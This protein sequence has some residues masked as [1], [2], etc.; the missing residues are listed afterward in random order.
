LKVRVNNV[1]R[2]IVVGLLFITLAAQPTVTGDPNGYYDTDGESHD[3]Y[4]GSL[5]AEEIDGEVGDDW[6]GWSHTGHIWCAGEEEP[7][8]D[9]WMLCDGER[10]YVGV[11]ATYAG[12]AMA[13]DG[14]WVRID[15][16]GDGFTDMDDNNGN[17]GETIFRLGGMSFEYVIPLDLEAMQNDTFN[18]LLHAE[19]TGLP[20][21]PEGETTTFPFRESGKFLYTGLVVGCELENQPPTAAIG[22]D[23]FCLGVTLYGSDSTD[24]DGSIVSYAWDFGDGATGSGEVVEHVYEDD[25]SYDVSLTVTDDKGYADTAAISLGVQNLP[26]EADAGEDRFAFPGA[27]VTFDGMA[28]RDPEGGELEFLWDFGD[29]TS[30][31]GMVMD[32][33]YADRGEYLVTLTVTDEFGAA[34]S[35]TCTVTVAQPAFDYSIEF[36]APADETIVDE[37]GIHFY[38]SGQ[39]PEKYH[40]VPFNDTFVIPAEDYGTYCLYNGTVNP[41]FDLTLTNTDALA[42]TDITITVIFEYHCDVTIWDYYGEVTLRKGQR[43]GDDC[44]LTWDVAELGPGESVSIYGT[45]DLY[46]RGWG[47]DQTHLRV[48]VMG[49]LVLDVPEA[50]VFCP[51]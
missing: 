37:Y 45:K 24:P 6:P 46:A 40:S 27:A 9:V 17:S 30:D 4:I 22:Y 34:G 39:N 50:G 49:A 16:D 7:V 32:K 20:S 2:V 42:Y 38:T 21:A 23:A 14:H 25:G 15:W 35:D 19:L 5:A 10:L 31:R 26:P 44:E 8:G 29:G 36:L 13:A 47:L 18:F 11:E 33:T 51:P 28:S 43:M 12:S 48:E 1:V 41:S 3:V